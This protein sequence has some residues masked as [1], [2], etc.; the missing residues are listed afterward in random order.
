MRRLR[1]QARAERAIDN[2]LGLDELRLVLAE[3][4]ATDLRSAQ[5]ANKRWQAVAADLFDDAE[6]QSRGCSL[7]LLLNSERACVDAVKQRLELWSAAIEFKLPYSAAHKLGLDADC[8]PGGVYCIRYKALIDDCGELLKKVGSMLVNKRYKLVI[9]PA[10]K[11]MVVFD[12]LIE[13]YTTKR[14]VDIGGRPMYEGKLP[15]YEIEFLRDGLFQTQTPLG[16]AWARLGRYD[17]AIAA[18]TKGLEGMKG[19]AVDDDVDDRSSVRDTMHLLGES[20]QAARRFG[21][22]EAMFRSALEMTKEIDGELSSIMNM[23]IASLAECL[24]EEASVS[25]EIMLKLRSQ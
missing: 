6:W 3:L 21:E 8:E 25:M 17:E 13:V 2:H 5:R 4:R 18:Y 11:L 9:V 10:Q 14:Y 22:A 19:K 20:L 12:F 7:Q 16:I 1:S 24:L 23:M 15:A